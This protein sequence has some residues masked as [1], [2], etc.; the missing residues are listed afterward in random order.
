MRD[1]A[2]GVLA[3]IVLLGLLGLSLAL[4]DLDLTPWRVAGHLG[5]AAL[6][7][8][9]IFAVFM[10]LREA[11]GLVR[12]MALGGLVW[13]AVLFGLTLLDYAFRA[14]SGVS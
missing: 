9:L 6:Q 12:V 1:V 4:T 5:V 14:P 3:W 7:A 13:L 8:A 11:G 2:R 10:R